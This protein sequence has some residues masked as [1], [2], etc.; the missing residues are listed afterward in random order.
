MNS[1]FYEQENATVAQILEQR[2]EAEKEDIIDQFMRE[3]EQ[4]VFE[5]ED[6]IDGL[7]AEITTLREELDQHITANAEF[8]ISAQKL[9]GQ[10]AREL[11]EGARA[12]QKITRLETRV[13]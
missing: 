9:K 7:Q 5:K 3:R 10:L 6:E 2:F 4:L 12:K 8:E 11:A 1:S 13:E